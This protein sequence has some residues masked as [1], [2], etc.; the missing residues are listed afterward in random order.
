M[1]A[2]EIKRANSH[3]NSP[4]IQKD[5]DEIYEILSEY[6][7]NATLNEQKD[8]LNRAITK[9][10]VIVSEGADESDKVA[11]QFNFVT[12]LIENLVQAIVYSLF[13]PKVL[14][15][16]EVNETLMGGK[17][18]KFDVKDLLM[19]MRSIIVAIIKEI[20]DLVLQELLRLVMEMLK[21]IIEFL[22]SVIAREQIENYV[23]AINFLIRNCPFIWFKFGNEVLL[24]T[25]LDTVDYADID[26]S[27]I[28]PGDKPNNTC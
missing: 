21:P 19:A 5:I 1:R 16:L 24:D 27:E 17:W 8:V 7:S 25:S 6:D 9:T 3:N 10:S 15:L 26:L 4:S 28:K 20:R 13:T 11:V 22:T 2:A 23:D 12:D 18:K 14:M